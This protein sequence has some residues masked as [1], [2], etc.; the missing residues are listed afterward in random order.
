MKENASCSKSYIKF[1]E[2]RVNYYRYSLEYWKVTLR[3]MVRVYLNC[4]LQELFWCPD[5]QTSVSWPVPLLTVIQLHILLSHK[6][7][8]T[9]TYIHCALLINA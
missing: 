1:Y 6:L 4:M 7:W 3:K 5:Y 8:R 9:R 2:V